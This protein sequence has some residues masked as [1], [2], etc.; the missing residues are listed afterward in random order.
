MEKRFSYLC[1][2][3]FYVFE[4]EYI[5][6]FLCVHGVLS[7]IKKMRNKVGLFISRR[8]IQEI[9]H[10]FYFLMLCG[11]CAYVHVEAHS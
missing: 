9:H 8:Y 6:T 4:C 5:H 2:C 1:F 11:M 10:L 7:E 3:V